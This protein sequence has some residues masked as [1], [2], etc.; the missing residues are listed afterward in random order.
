MAF[1]SVIVRMF[2]ASAG[3]ALGGGGMADDAAAAVTRDA[4]LIAWGTGAIVVLA[5]L[6]RRWVLLSFA[7]ILFGATIVFL[8]GS[9]TKN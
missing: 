4:T 2:G 8:G 3:L 7:L 5:M 6:G 9:I 1:A